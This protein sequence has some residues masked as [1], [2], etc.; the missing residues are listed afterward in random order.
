MQRTKEE[1]EDEIESLGFPPDINDQIHTIIPRLHPDLLRS[2]HVSTLNAASL[3]NCDSCGQPFVAGDEM[4]LDVYEQDGLSATSI[5]IQQ[6]PIRFRNTSIVLVHV[7]SCLG[8]TC[9]KAVHDY[10][11]CV[12]FSPRPRGNPITAGTRTGTVWTDFRWATQWVAWF[13]QFTGSD[14]SVELTLG[15]RR[16]R[17]VTGIDVPPAVVL[18][19]HKKHD[20]IDDSASISAIRISLELLPVA[21]IEALFTRVYEIDLVYRGKMNA[22]VALGECVSNGSFQAVS[23]AFV[24]SITVDGSG[25]YGD[26]RADEQYLR[27]LIKTRPPARL[28]HA[29]MTWYVNQGNNLN[30]VDLQKHAMCASGE[31]DADE[32]SEINQILRGINDSMNK[33]EFAFDQALKHAKITRTTPTRKAARFKLLA[34]IKFKREL[35][36]SRTRIV[37]TSNMHTANGKESTR[38]YLFRENGS[39]RDIPLMCFEGVASGTFPI[40]V[41]NHKMAVDEMNEVGLSQVPLPILTTLQ[42]R[43]GSISDKQK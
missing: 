36:D 13:Y 26:S 10:A 29:A 30:W 8:T 33:D 16:P 18:D 34:S 43:Y 35:N 9:A 7:A 15:S 3:L 38:Y 21:C 40:V 23:C 41:C 19:L 12:R 27:V 17:L 22:I 42:M 32:H 39:E 24:H 6:K 28:L 37:F 25:Q 14:D 4:M 2:R 1:E 31:S 20:E 11:N 5:R